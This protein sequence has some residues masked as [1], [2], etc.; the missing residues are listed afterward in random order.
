VIGVMDQKLKKT[1]SEGADYVVD[2]AKSD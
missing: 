1:Y 2:K